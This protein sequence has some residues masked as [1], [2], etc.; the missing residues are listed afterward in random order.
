M[1]HWPLGNLAF[2]PLEFLTLECSPHIAARW[3]PWAR[4]KVQQIRLLGL[5]AHVW[6]PALGVRVAV[7]QL[8]DSIVHITIQSSAAGTYQ[9]IGSG[10]WLYKTFRDPDLPMG[11][12]RMLPLGYAVLL[13]AKQGR[14]KNTPLFSSIDAPPS[15]EWV[16][17]PDPRT[18]DHA[19]TFSPMHQPDGLG[20]SF[21]QS[22]TPDVPK[23]NLP[24]L[25]TT[26]QQAHPCEGMA[27][28]SGG[29]SAWFT[30]LD[31]GYD[32]N[33]H[34]F[35]DTNPLVGAS[36][37]PDSDWYGQ[38]AYTTVDGRAFIIMVDV[39]SVFYCYPPEAAETT[40]IY[41][42]YP[43]QAGNVPTS[44]VKS[45]ACP[46]PAWVTAEPLGMAAIN[47]GVD[48]MTHINRLRPLWRFNHAG[49][50][51]ACIMGHR[52]ANWADGYFAS[53]FYDAAGTLQ[54]TYQE[55]YPGMVEVAFTITTTGPGL[56][57][58]TFVVTLRQDMDS[59]VDH[60]TPV[61][62]GY[63]VR[64]MGG[65][66]VDALLVLEYQHYIDNPTMTTATPTATHGSVETYTLKRPN[67]ATVAVV[68]YQT[69]AG[70]VE[71]RRWLAYYACYPLLGDDRLFY[72]KIEEFSALN[73][74][75]GYA[76]HLR[77]IANILSLELSSLSVCISATLS[78]KGD[79]Q[80]GSSTFQTY[81]AEA[82]TIAVIAFNQERHRQSIGHSELQPIASSMLDLDSTYP[83]LANFT[84]FDLG[85]TLQYAI[86]DASGWDSNAINLATR[87]ATLTVTD[88]Q[89]GSWARIVEGASENL[90]LYDTIAACPLFSGHSAIY[91]PAVFGYWDGAANVRPGIRW[92][93]SGTLQPGTLN[94]SDYPYGV[95]HHASVLFLT[96]AGMNNVGHRFST[97]RNGSW[98][99]FAG[100]FAART[101]LS[102]WYQ[103]G[104]LL[105]APSLAYEQTVVDLI[106]IHDDTRSSETVT[107]HIAAL[108]AA[109]GKSW[110]PESYY[111]NLRY[112]ATTGAE[113]Q[114]SVSNPDAP[115]WYPVTLFSPLGVILSHQSLIGHRWHNEFCFDTAFVTQQLHYDDNSFACFPT[116]RQEG[117]WIPD[118]L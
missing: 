66:P 24:A 47:L 111:F 39:N 75:T 110:T 90:A 59:Q 4:H 116:P 48:Y 40:P 100:P 42:G 78:T 41:T 34:V 77:F 21:W 2:P 35:T 88:G 107:T 7:R 86:F 60:R 33:P 84:A 58:F 74:Q 46:W 15:S 101:D 3:L 70:W 93:V 22:P 68:S 65:I 67:K 29:S 20:V 17:N 38:A 36:K 51:A 115:L 103:N 118:G 26:W 1:E 53:T 14:I 79:I 18:T 9:F 44:H 45:Q 113:F 71:I 6:Q 52:A 27:V 30:T 43:G 112:N 104:V 19:L 102:P 23:R 89:G 16:Y 50:R 108:N 94:F 61:D 81:A 8:D 54:T 10:P 82:M 49:T 28:Y 63:A 91:G 31:F 55:D 62:V 64:P 25:V 92:A 83:D 11:Y 57:D 98:A 95:L 99:L 56:D 37:A 5:T 13:D 12:D 114:P 69:D 117:G 87:Y 106:G 32:V 105:T 76:N 109:F 73:G 72:P 96:C 80:T 85:A 97:H